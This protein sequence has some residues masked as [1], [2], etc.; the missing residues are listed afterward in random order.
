MNL[1]VNVS[2]SGHVLAHLRMCVMCA[3]MVE[4]LCGLGWGEGVVNMRG[5]VH[6][7]TNVCVCVR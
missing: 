3:P 7:S 2:I 4:D 5:Y 6:G 1:C